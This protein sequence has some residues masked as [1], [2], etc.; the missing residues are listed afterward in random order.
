MHDMV[1]MSA[2]LSKVTPPRMRGVF[3]RERLFRL[4]DGLGDH[5]ALWVEAPGGSG[6][7]TLV[8]SH[9]DSRGLP[10]LWYQI[11]G[12]DADVATFFHYLGE[13]AGRGGRGKRKRLPACSPDQL[14]SLPLFARRFFTSLFTLLPPS[15]TIV[16]D[17]YQDLPANARL[18]EVIREALGVIPLGARIVVISRE[19]PPATFARLLANGIIGLV[20]WEEL[21]LDRDEA[22]E[23]IRMKGGLELPGEKLGYLYDKTEGWAAGLVLMVEHLRR[24]GPDLATLERVDPGGVFDY[25]AAEIF[26]LADAEMQDFLLKTAFLNR[27]TVP[28]AEKLSGNGRAHQLL[29]GLARSNYFTTRHQGREAS[30]QYHQLFQEFLRARARATLAPAELRG[31]KGRT[32]AL[33]KG[34]GFTEDAAKI[35]A[36]LEEWDS[37]TE[38]ALQQ[39]QVLVAQGRSGLLGEWLA[40]L[41]SGV[42]DRNP[43]V[44][45]WL[46]ACRL[47]AS[48]TESRALLENAF[49]LFRD[50]GDRTGLFLSW[51]G[52][53]ETAIHA[54]EYVPM[55]RW[56]EVLDDVLK[57]E[58]AFP[59]REIEVRVALS[60]FNAAAFVLPNHP[61]IDAIRERAY[62]LVCTEKI[63]DA[64]LF[65]SSGIHLVVHFIY[66]GDFTRAGL[67]LDLLRTA[68]KA[69]EATDLV[70]IMVKTIEAHYAFATCALD[71]CIEKAFEALS[72]AATNG[73]HIWDT[74]LYGHAVAAALA[75][76]DEK[77]AAELMP[78]M[79]AGLGACRRVDKA[80]YYWLLAWSAALQGDFEQARRSQELALSLVA[81]VG[82][83]APETVSL[84]NM[85]EN[86]V[87]LGSDGEAAAYLERAIP[88]V[89]GIGSAYLSCCY[90]LVESHLQFKRGN[91]AQGLI[92]LARAFC[93][94]RERRIENFYFWRP[95]IMT[96]L[97]LKALEAGIEVDYVRE[98]ISRRGLVPDEPPLH[99]ANWPWPLKVQTLGR[100]ALEREG[101][102]L[103][104]TGKVQKKPLELLK[105]LV[106]LGGREAREGEVADLL[107][108]DADGD[109]A[110]SS[111]KTTLHRLRQLIGC[112]E[113]VVLRE[114][115]LSLNRRHVWT[116]VWAFEHLLREAQLR[117]EGGDEAGAVRLTEEAL[118]LYR[119]HFLAADDKPWLVPL[120]ERLASRFI[121]GVT[122]LGNLCAGKGEFTQALSRYEQAL[123]VDD[124]SEQLYQG[125]IHCYLAAGLRSEAIAT[126]LRC[127]K[128]L[129]S[130]LGIEP[131]ARTVALYS[132]ALAAP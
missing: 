83:I 15:V 97:C 110:R 23:L 14:L 89:Q 123:I 61:D 11:D 35:Y 3:P 93:L 54:S 86:L 27:I 106:A 6:K 78:K 122:A 76:G 57:K 82:F 114:G 33:L 39:A 29:S 127:R 102:P 118:A 13:A 42:A 96:R 52:V 63:A 62:L 47:S 2:S 4:V 131:S 65:L 98:L 103:D 68:A 88:L 67:I 119:G 84:I 31:L 108:P 44:L 111:L 113:A 112:E 12:G 104:F 48:P 74:H 79:A 64:N 19:A 80:Y 90:S 21:R 34:A 116:D 109:T 105:A 36:D 94:A 71:T 81:E 73:V 100:F 56:I 129:A 75:K 87:E 72:L 16:F 59:S 99:L 7:S 69:K 8:A 32:A 132:Q 30:F 124:R 10:H 40:E 128:V 115:C 24:A 18:H 101:A 45:F 130:S 53:V 70:L 5:P 25:F 107:W 60:L 55:R 46:G 66:Q 51:C 58:P 117:A 9:L 95:A 26:D 1:P 126:F 125:L 92:S 85:A 41:P 77:L 91:E 120:R 43:W 20:G 121:L 38:M 49:A 28:V 50:S 37:L 22:R 17:N